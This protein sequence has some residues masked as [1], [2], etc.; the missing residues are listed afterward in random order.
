MRRPYGAKQA[1]VFLKEVLAAAPDVPVQIAHLA[2]AGGYDDPAVDEALSVFVDAIA[3]S[4]PLMT[5]VYFDVSGVAGIG[6]WT[7]AKAAQVAARMRQLGLHRVVY[8][9][10]A[11]IPSNT[12]PEAWEKFK[13]IP[14]S[15]SEV[16]IIESNIAPYMR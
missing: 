4:D 11:P 10:D 13:S 1:R 8:G 6:D 2:G 9:S 3:A 15:Q 14:L 5:N 12:P 7:A 16:E